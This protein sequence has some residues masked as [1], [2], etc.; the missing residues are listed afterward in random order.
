MV[1]YYTR[2]AA[3]SRKRGRRTPQKGEGCVCTEAFKHSSKAPR[4]RQSSLARATASASRG[5]SSRS[6]L[7]S[8]WRYPFGVGQKDALAALRLTALLL[9]A[10]GTALC[11]VGAAR[12]GGRRLNGFAFC[13]LLIGA[14]VLCTS[15]PLLVAMLGVRS[16]R[17]AWAGRFF[18]FEREGA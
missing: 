9:A 8:C 10:A 6:R 2:C 3:F 12:A 18:F 7:P 1:S 5:G 4:G 15:A 16:A 11:G 13:G 14:A 17:L